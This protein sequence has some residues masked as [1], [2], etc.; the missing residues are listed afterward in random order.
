VN[1][2]LLAPS[3][4][5]V[6]AL[7]GCGLKGPLYLPEKSREVIIRPAPGTPAEAA[8]PSEAPPAAE[9]A[10]GTGVEPKAP[11]DPEAPPPG[12]DHG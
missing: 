9:P 10:T 8:T 2:R 12:T 11:S 7:A 4:A 6:T 5:L 1:G 3:L